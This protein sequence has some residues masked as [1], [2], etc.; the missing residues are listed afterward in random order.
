MRNAERS[1]WIELDDEDDLYLAGSADYS[2]R[3]FVLM[4]IKHEIKTGGTDGEVLQFDPFEKRRQR[5]AH[6]LH[7]A[8][9]PIDLKPKA[10]L[11]GLK[12]GAGCPGKKSIGRTA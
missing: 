6:K 10:C 1:I 12:P 3:H 9:R 11:Q 2:Q 7:Q 5:W 4:A 8:S